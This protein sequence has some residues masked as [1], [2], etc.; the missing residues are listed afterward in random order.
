VVAVEQMLTDSFGQTVKLAPVEAGPEGT[1]YLSDDSKV[2]G[3][4]IDGQLDQITWCDE[5]G[6]LDNVKEMP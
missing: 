2:A 4:F 5:L 3:L 6:P 1:T